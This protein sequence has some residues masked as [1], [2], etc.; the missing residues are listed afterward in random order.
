MRTSIVISTYNQPKSLRKTL[1]GL[2]PQTTQDFEV[3]VADDGSDAQTAEVIA[4]SPFASLSVR[5]V[6]HADTGFRLSAIRN[7]AIASSDA[8]YLI[9]CDGDCV[10][11]DDFIASHIRHARTGYFVAGG[12]INVPPAVHETF[13]DDDIRSNRVFDVDFLSSREPNLGRYRGRLSRSPLQARCGDWLTWRY[14]VFN[15]SNTGVW[16][17]GLERVNGFD[18]RFAGYGSEDRDLGVRLRNAGVRS[19]YRKY[20]LAMLHFDHPQAYLDES[21]AQQNRQVFRRRWR[22]GTTR[23]SQGLDTVLE[24]P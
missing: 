8:D 22:D 13:S 10:V 11:R 9:F 20:S 15:G 1:L 19:M 18:E 21:I 17:E 5:H 6:W 4:E 24:R 12:R 23:I 3:V 2:L 16:R 14:C 7:R